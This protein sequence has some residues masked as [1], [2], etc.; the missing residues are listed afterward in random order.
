MTRLLK[1][2]LLL[3]AIPL[4]LFAFSSPLVRGFEDRP[5]PKSNP[6]NAAPAPRTVPSTRAPAAPLTP[7][8]QVVLPADGVAPPSGIVPPAGSPPPNVVVPPVEL[9]GQNVEQ[10]RRIGEQIFNSFVNPGAPGQ[11][12][13]PQKPLQPVDVNAGIKEMLDRLISGDRAIESLKIQFDPQ[14]TDFARDMAKLNADVGLRYSAWSKSPSRLTLGL[15]A[16]MENPGNM[17]SR[18]VVGG[19]LV[20]QTDVVALVNHLLPRIKKRMGIEGDGRVVV[21]GEKPATVQNDRRG[22]LLGRLRRNARDT[23]VAVQAPAPG[24]A[25]A[26]EAPIDAPV[27]VT[28]ADDLSFKA[29]LQDKLARTG[30]VKSMDELVDLFTYI[31]GL[32]L[33]IQNEK[34]EGLIAAV[35]NAPSD[36]A[37]RRAAEELA[38]ARQKRDAMLYTRLSV[39]RDSAGFARGFEIVMVESAAVT[40]TKIENLN[41]VVSEQQ[42][43]VTGSTRLFQGLELYPFI[44]PVVMN[45]LRNVQERDA[46]LLD[47]QRGPFSGLWQQGREAVVGPPEVIQTP[48]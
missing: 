31:S 24:R 26:P 30:T 45:F 27:G 5:A 8:P 1:R 17:P 4:A 39:N 16:K 33:C 2:I 40:G 9:R 10:F 25:P 41:V 12:G 47:L 43:K 29:Q 35:D 13:A 18:A 34:I 36:Q 3:G 20:L 14:Q 32:S 38:E 28:T 23:A 22:P 6:K 46:I 15:N 11:G 37:R 48:Q 42:V 21:D 19:E 44:K 7:P